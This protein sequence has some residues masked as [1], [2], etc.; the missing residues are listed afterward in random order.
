VVVRGSRRGA[1]LIHKVRRFLIA[2]RSASLT[3]GL[4]ENTLGPHMGW[5][6]KP[7]ELRWMEIE[8]E[9]E[10]DRSIDRSTDR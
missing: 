5:M 1:G 10:M 4:V 6:W 3:A 9:S 2:V 8:G 7:T